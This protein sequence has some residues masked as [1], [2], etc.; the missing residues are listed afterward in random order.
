MPTG[1]KQAG[2]TKYTYGASGIPGNLEKV[3]VIE[4]ATGATVP[5][6]II[7][8]DLVYYNS[9]DLIPPTRLPLA[10]FVY[11]LTQ[12]IPAALKRICAFIAAIGNP[13]PITDGKSLKFNVIDNG[14]HLAHI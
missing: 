12:T 2:A 10:G 3:A 7:E 4:L 6:D 1:L 14:V 8:Y 13:V 11:T 5:P 9:P